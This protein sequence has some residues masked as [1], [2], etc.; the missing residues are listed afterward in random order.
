MVPYREQ[1][2]PQAEEAMGGMGPQRHVL[3]D[4]FQIGN[5]AKNI[6]LFSARVCYA[7]LFLG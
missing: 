1:V 4:A 3:E 6:P 2:L 5:P 7:L